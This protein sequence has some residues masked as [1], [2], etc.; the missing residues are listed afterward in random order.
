MF[1]TMGLIDSLKWADLGNIS[2]TL[3]LVCAQMGTVNGSQCITL[4]MV[5]TLQALI[6]YLGVG[7]R[8]QESQ[9]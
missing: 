5:G 4:Q 6:V 9:S 3:S 8:Y 1:H 2:I 7:Q